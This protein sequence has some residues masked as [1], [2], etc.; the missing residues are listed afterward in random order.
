[1][2]P[3]FS[4][5]TGTSPSVVGHGVEDRAARAAHPRARAGGAVA[6]RDLVRGD[7]P[8]EVVDAHRVDELDRTAEPLDPPP[9]ARSCADRGPVVH[10][11]APSLSVGAPVVG[12]HAADHARLEQLGEPEVVGAR[13]RDR[14]RHVAEDPHAALA[15]RG[16]A[17]GAT[18]DRTAPGRRAHRVRRTRPTDPTRTDARPRTP[19]SRRR[20]P[21]RRD[22][23]SRSGSRRTPRSMRTASRTGRVDRR[24]GSATTL[25][26]VGQ[27]VDEAQRVVA[28][29]AARAA[30]RP[31]AA[32]RSHVR[33]PVIV[34]SSI[35]IAGAWGMSDGSCPI[36]PQRT[37]RLPARVRISDVTP[38]LECGRYAVE[39]RRRAR[40][41]RSARPSSPTATCRCAP[42]CATGA[43]VPG[44][45]TASRC[46]RRATSPTASPPRSGSRRP[47]GGS[48]PS[49]PGSTPRAT[50][51]DE[52]RRKVE[53]GETE[54]AAELA[55]GEQLLGVELPDVETALDAPAEVRAA[56][57][58]LGRPLTVVAEPVLAAFG[59]W[60]ELFPRSFGGFDG[61][62]AVLPEIADLG[63][64]VVYLPPI[65]P[66]G[67]TNRKGRNNALVGGARRSGEPVGDRRRRGWPQGGAP[68]PRHPRRLRPPRRT[69]PRARPRDRARLRG[70]VLAR[71]SVA[72]EAPR[73]VR[74]AARRLGEVRGEP[75]EALPGHRQRRL[76]QPEGEAA[77]GGAARRG[78]ALDRARRARVPRRQPAHQAVRVLGVADR[79]GA[80][81]A[82]R[83]RVPRRGVHAP[84]GDVHAGQARLQ[85]VV[86]LLHV[87]QHAARSSR[88]T[89][90]SS[91]RRPTGSGRT[92]S[93]TRPT[94][95][96]STCST[97][98]NPRSKPAPCSRRR[99][100][101]RG[102]C[103]RASS[104]PP[105][106][107]CARGAR[108][109]ATRRSTSARPARSA[110]S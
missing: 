31:G 91:R 87:A 14:E 42:S 48:T 101:R 70:A 32:R 74:V 24:A 99:C 106:S 4:A 107:R 29:R 58:S 110:A 44:A 69:R 65:H 60:Y 62:R 10:R 17:G 64:D 80:R 28:Q 20:R 109:T 78:R 61:V 89:W 105:A 13:G 34:V 85:P 73:V 8:A 49:A 54:L 77:L 98:A 56:K 26:G 47:V 11:R 75:A 92:S 6:R 3:R 2:S 50:W 33:T 52:L 103:T 82:P 41:S 7:E 53:A 36:G 95:S 76:R 67:T 51:H 21:A 71:P 96:T 97:A 84:G 102:A 79:D 90:A 59:A 94:S 37:H 1:M 86:H 108:S 27:P 72:R 104:A 12:R 68:R 45:G 16:C 88:P 25:A 23:R 93:S 57:T 35:G 66:I 40:P 63:F 55:E 38:Q 39:A 100:R 9:V 30:T 18:R 43:S 22:R 5:T 46:S 19:R 81:A 83:R 15:R